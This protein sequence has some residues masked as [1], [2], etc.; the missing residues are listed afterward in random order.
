MQ[1]EKKKR[2]EKPSLCVI[3]AGVLPHSRQKGAKAQ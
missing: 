3:R 1:E 2:K